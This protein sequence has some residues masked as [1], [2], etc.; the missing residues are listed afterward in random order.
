M[1]RQD[2]ALFFFIGMVR[3]VSKQLFHGIKFFGAN[4]LHEANIGWIPFTKERRLFVLSGR[5]F[6]FTGVDCAVPAKMFQ[7]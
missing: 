5:L 2:L 3:Q 1:D 4:D 7:N 6:V